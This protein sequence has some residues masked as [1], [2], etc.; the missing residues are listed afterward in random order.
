MDELLLL[1]RLELVV[2]ATVH[3][4]VAFVPFCL[5]SAT[6]DATIKQNNPRFSYLHVYVSS[7]LPGVNFFGVPFAISDAILKQF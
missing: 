5:I 3:L 1:L 2:A 4:D 7:A 6:T